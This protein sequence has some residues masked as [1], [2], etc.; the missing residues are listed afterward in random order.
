MTGDDDQLAGLAERFPAWRVG[1]S[2]TPGLFFAWL[3]GARSPDHG[4]LLVVRGATPDELAE[5]IER[6]IAQGP[7]DPAA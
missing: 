7:G 1:R 2:R 6:E 5:A 3:P 4:G